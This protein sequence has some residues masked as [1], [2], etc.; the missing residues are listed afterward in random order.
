MEREIGREE[1]EDWFIKWKVYLETESL[2]LFTLSIGWQEL[3]GMKKIYKKEKR[4]S[5][6]E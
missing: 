6:N 5:K 4:K 3:K 1:G 2:V